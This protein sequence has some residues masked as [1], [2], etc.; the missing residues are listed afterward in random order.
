MAK[1][2]DWAN[3]TSRFVLS[4]NSL[5][6]NHDFLTSLYDKPFENVVGKG[7]SAGNQHFLLLP[8]CFLSFL[9]KKKKKSVTFILSS[10]NAFNLNQ[11]KYLSF[12]KELIQ[13]VN[14]IRKR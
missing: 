8:Q 7:E 1:P 9:G 3:Q 12:G 13:T 5:P 14:A 4:L 10:A 11:T 2:F 6:H